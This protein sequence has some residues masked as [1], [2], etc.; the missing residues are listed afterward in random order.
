MKDTSLWRS[1]SM[2]AIVKHQGAFDSS[3]WNWT[4]IAF[5]FS[6]ALMDGDVRTWRNPLQ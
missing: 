3:H 6:L 5:R 4:Q 1:T 2:L